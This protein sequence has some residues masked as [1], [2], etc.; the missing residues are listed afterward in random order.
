MAA[1]ER[2]NEGSLIINT[3]HGPV[4]YAEVGGQHDYYPVLLVIHGAGGGYDQGIILSRVLLPNDSLVIA[5]FTIW[6][7]VYSIT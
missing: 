4:E 3:V 6:F 7:L 2:V 5:P 1:R